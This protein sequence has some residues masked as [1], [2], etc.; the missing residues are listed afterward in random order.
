MQ[1]SKNIRIRKCLLS[2][3]QSRLSKVFYSPKEDFKSIKT[4]F[5]CKEASD[6]FEN[7]ENGS[8]SKLKPIILK[9]TNKKVITS[10]NAPEASTIP[11]FNCL[12]KSPKC[13][14]ESLTPNSKSTRF[15]KNSEKLLKLIYLPKEKHKSAKQHL[16]NAQILKNFSYKP[17][18]GWDSDRI[19]E[20]SFGEIK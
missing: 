10:I 12:E 18:R 1:S 19:L 4:V 17:K 15:N 13:I 6:P 14:N 11:K 2:P 5:K 7:L 20:M 3:N 16:E 9:K 8:K